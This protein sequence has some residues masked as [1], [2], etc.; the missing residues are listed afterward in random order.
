MLIRIFAFLTGAIVLTGL[1]GWWFEIEIYAAVMFLVISAKKVTLATM[2]A[3]L[4]NLLIGFF[5][6]Y[7]PRKILSSSLIRYFIDDKSR[8][9]IIKKLIHKRNDWVNKLGN[10]DRWV[11]KMKAGPRWF[12]AMV[13]IGLVIAASLW[14]GIWFIFLIFPRE[15]T[16]LFTTLLEMLGEMFANT[17]L[18]TVV[19]RFY[20][21]FSSTKLGIAFGKLNH[22]I[23]HRINQRIEK[24]GMRHRRNVATT[25]LGQRVKSVWKQY[26]KIP[27][28]IMPTPVRHNPPRSPFRQGDIKSHRAA[29]RSGIKNPQPLTR[30]KNPLNRRK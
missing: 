30:L 26:L 3:W 12:L 11:Q 24:V 20:N 10:V 6:R 15:L 25:R 23:E 29:N 18:A 7:L 9:L 22:W 1:L 19:T 8:E 4:R 17:G 13:T 16:A 28:V 2:L 5:L 21:W 27:T 14:S